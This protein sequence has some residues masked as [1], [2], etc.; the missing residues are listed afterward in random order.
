M[1]KNRNY[2]SE[3]LNRAPLDMSSGGEFVPPESRPKGGKKGAV[4]PR[5]GTTAKSV[6]HFDGKRSETRASRYRHQRHAAKLMTG[7]GRVGQCRHSVVSKSA[8]VDVVLSNYR[9]TVGNFA[10]YEGLQTCGS[11][12]LCPC[13]GARISET[14]RGELN[15]L[16]SWARGE[17]H[18]VKM[19][20]LTARH[21]RD[22]DLAELLDAMKVA[23]QRFGQ[24]RKYRKI[25]KSMMGSVT[26]T[27]VTCGCQH[28][29]HPHF[30][31]IVIT[32]EEI[33]LEELRGVWLASLRGAG[34]D[35]AGAAFQVQNAEAAGRYIT[36][37]GAAEELTMTNEKKGK[38]GRTPA[39][40]LAASCDDGDRQAGMLWAEYAKAFHGRRQLVWSRGLKAMAGIDQVDDKEAAENEKQAE[41]EE[42]GR[43]NIPHPVW[44][45]DVV[46]RNVDRRSELQDRVEEVGADQ[47]V[48]E[49]IAGHAPNNEDVIEELWQPR[50]GGLAARA[51]ASIP[52]KRKNVQPECDK[53][54]LNPV[55]I[56][57]GEVDAVPP[58]A[59]RKIKA[60]GT[61]PGHGAEGVSSARRQRSGTAQ[62]IGCSSPA[63]PPE[64]PQTGPP[65]RRKMVT[66]W[67]GAARAPQ[68]LHMSSETFR[69]ELSQSQEILS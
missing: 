42:V 30:H 46:P 21:G 48:A 13:C 22:D 14:R 63:G 17:G 5:L 39:Q 49:L 67:V 35:G 58:D 54:P 26:A 44:V 55:Y 11:V 66:L 10:H 60:V 38:G 7:K 4:G 56:Y 31:M 27:E 8:G 40:L 1:L 23:K 52:E 53:S 59:V 51:L 6:G 2:F 64:A 19:I 37:W 34:L 12:W 29:W 57:D 41:Q 15:Q 28:G 3:K 65:G 50:P 68:S 45:G 33:D 16:L 62:A 20:T 61:K 69:S 47:A 32:D 43:A 18:K 25:K 36:K 9:D 24:H